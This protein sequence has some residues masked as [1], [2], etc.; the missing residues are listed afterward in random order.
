MI[1]DLPFWGPPGVYNRP[2]PYIWWI[3]TP[4]LAY[5]AAAWIGHTLAVFIDAW[6]K[7]FG[8]GDDG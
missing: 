3:V 1:A 4:P 8:G 5:L 6:H 2:D 7:V